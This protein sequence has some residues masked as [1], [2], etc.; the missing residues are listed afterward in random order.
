MF[1]NFL[2]LIIQL[3]SCAA[4]GNLAGSLLKRFSLG[5]LGNS[6]AG[7]AGG[8]I[9]D[10]ILGIIGIEAGVDV[11]SATDIANIFSSIASGGI[12]G[13]AI[14]AVIAMIKKA[15]GGNSQ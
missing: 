10:S 3:L 13:G 9:G 15:I 5:I 1:M 2:P 8:G 12:G 14:I 7:I 11:V 4:G 6:L